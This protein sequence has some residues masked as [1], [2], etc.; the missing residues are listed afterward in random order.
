MVYWNRP[1]RL[2]SLLLPTLTLVCTSASGQNIPDFL[3]PGELAIVDTG[4]GVVDSTIYIP[5]MRFPLE[6]PPAFVNSQV[7]RPGGW[8]F[9]S[10][11]VQSISQC[12]NSNYDYPWQDTFCERRGKLNKYEA[13]NCPSGYGHGGIDIR[14]STC[15]D[16][17]HWAVAVED[18][19][20]VQIKPM[21]VT[22]LIEKLDLEVLYLHLDMDNL[23]PNIK[24]GSLIKKGDRI[25]KVSNT[26]Q[27]GKNNTTYHLHFE[28]RKK[29]KTEG[30]RNFVF[31][32]PYYTLLDSYARL[33]KL[34]ENDG[35]CF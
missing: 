13:V 24:K 19:K 17:T 29:A 20:I 8:Q 32:S 18:G 23:H 30:T 16:K 9:V 14:P 33:C 35:K 4:K 2:L 21:S 1:T 11:G 12:T 3:P 6:N 15:D 5:N 27:D 10:D 7:Y 22:L 34:P 28:I 25:G 31:V 26:T